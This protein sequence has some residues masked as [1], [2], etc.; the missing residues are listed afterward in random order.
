MI[1]INSESDVDLDINSVYDEY[2]MNKDKDM[3]DCS[4]DAYINGSNPVQNNNIVQ[5]QIKIE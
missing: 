3:T 1:E 4:H 5:G 2:E